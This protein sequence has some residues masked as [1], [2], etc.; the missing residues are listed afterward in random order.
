MPLN[1]PEGTSAGGSGSTSPTSHSSDFWGANK[2]LY[3][4]RA[5]GKFQQCY[6]FRSARIS[7][8]TQRVYLN[9]PNRPPRLW[10]GCGHK[11]F[12]LTG[13]RTRIL[14]VGPVPATYKG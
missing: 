3:W 12:L 10:V 2:S 7:E 8:L 5:Q 13:Q 9:L 1:R 6:Q 14:C 4:V 11:A